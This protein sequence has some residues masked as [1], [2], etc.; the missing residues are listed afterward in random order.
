MFEI[1]Y[2]KRFRMEL[3]LRRPVLAVP[4]LPDNY[5]WL[6]WDNSLLNAHACTKAECFHGEIDVDVFHSLGSEDGCRQLMR[7]IQLKPGFLPG[8]TWLIGYGS[9]F[10]GTVQGVRERSGWGAIQ[11]L[12]VI[13]SHRGRGLGTALILQAIAGF[14]TAC[15]PGVYLEVTA[16]NDPAVQ[17]YRK[18]GFR[19][20]KTVYKAVEQ[21]YFYPIAEPTF[22]G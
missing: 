2:F 22:V 13:P 11:N 12:G 7:A 16:S 5:F 14:Q 21:P 10:V 1:R 8:A 9:E 3:D 18:V 20:R 15:L 4:P 6:P 17:L 19:C